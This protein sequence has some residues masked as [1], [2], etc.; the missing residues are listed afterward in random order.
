LTVS[1]NA[2]ANSLP[3]GGYSDAV[4]FTNVTSGAG[5]TTRP[6]SLT[7]SDRSPLI[8]A[9]GSTLVSEG[10]TPTN[11]VIDP[12]EVVTVSF[13]VANT[14][15]GDT[16]NLVAT[17]LATNGVASPSGP[18]TY[19]VVRAGGAASTQSFNFTASG[20]CGGNITATLQLQDGLAN[21]GSITY[22][23]PLGLVVNPLTQNFDGVT[24]P[25]LPAGW[26]TSASGAESNW[27]TS[28]ASVDS[29][30]N[31]AFSPDPGIVGI[32]ELDTP[33]IAIASGSAVLTFRQNYN[34]AASPTNSSLGLDGGVLEIKMGSGSYTDILAAGGSFVS[35]GYN[36][37]VIGTN[38]NP[39]IGRQ[40][41]SGN[42]GGFTT[43]VV[44]LPAAAAGQNV[45]LR[46]RCGAGNVP[47][48]SVAS[49][50]TL[51]YWNF[52]SSSP[53]ANL[54]AT[55]ITAAP[56]AVSNTGGSL[57]YF[58]GNPGNAIASSGFTQ[59]AGPPTSGYS[60]FSFNLTVTNGSLA[61][62]SKLSFDD[63]ASGTG[64]A[65]F[66]VQISRVAN[67]SS[68]IYDSGAKSTHPAFTATPMN[69]LT[70]TNSGLT[71]TIYFR[72]YAFG[73]GG[74]GGTWRIDNLTVQGNV[75][76]TGGAAG[77]GWYIDSV[78]ISDFTCCTAPTNNPPTASFSAS[79]TNGVEP[80]VVT[81]TDTSTGSITSRSWDFG[82]NATTNVTTNAVVHTYAA[83]NYGVTLVVTGP[84]G[85]GTNTQAN[86]ITV[87]TAFQNWQ[88]QYFGS[89]NNPA[90]APT[91]DP[92]GDGQNNMA[93]FLAGTDPTN[94]AS[95]FRITSI[96]REGN[97]FRITW[98]TGIGRTNSLQVAPGDARGSYSNDFTDL[99]VVTNT[100]GTTTNYLDLGAATN[101]LTGYYRVR[102]VP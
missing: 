1:I 35:G 32:N 18:Q 19:G 83:G 27:V 23:F 69:S 29:S 20:V 97:D 15:S 13:S 71:G 72:I 40:A 12:G 90:A 39:L 4:S 9:N 93:E 66:D 61:N 58:S 99:F 48:N 64:P 84:G 60:Y 98:M 16:A 92:D 11:G 53:I 81:F 86:C 87:L 30:P 76:G 67:F 78:S 46:W 59:S 49:S 3:S 7:I 85:V 63:R 47:T 44:N 10:C 57:T 21:L 62:L 50:G 79:P 55:N 31:A 34:L 14:G 28:T 36:T 8:V 26:T 75:A 5:N 91:A 89:T 51:A 82:D 24:A 43:T 25:T 2:N 17:L 101:A 80:L 88:I 22:T 33:T 68:V 37:T 42:S 70:L 102:L 45:Q 77:A 38:G 100:V 41:W 73:A 65:S 96:A 6:V 95:T 56:V 54:T 52:D 74:S 94:N